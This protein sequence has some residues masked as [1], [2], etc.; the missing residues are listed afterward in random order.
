[1]DPT[2]IRPGKRNLYADMNLC[3]RLADAWEASPPA[4]PPSPSGDD[5][6]ADTFLNESEGFVMV[7]CGDFEEQFDT[8]GVPPSL[9]ASHVA[10]KLPQTSLLAMGKDF[11]RALGKLLTHK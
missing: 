6:W 2:Y 11:G 10:D 5:S 1:M 7:E 8:E 3:A 4:P 9:E